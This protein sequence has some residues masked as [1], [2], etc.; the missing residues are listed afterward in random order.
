MPPKGS[1]LPKQIGG[2][3]A[4]KGWKPLLDALRK[5]RQPRGPLYDP[6]ATRDVQR[7]HI[8]LSLLLSSQTRDE[9][10]SAAME[11]LRGQTFVA[12]KKAK[13]PLTVDS[14]SGCTP[15]AVSKLTEEQ[16]KGLIFGVRFYNN[17]TRY[18]KAV[19]D[20]IVTKHGG[21]V[22]SDYDTL[23]AMPGL[24][25]KMVHLFM[26][27][28]DG[29]LTGIGVDT[30]V[31]RIARR[32]EWTPPSAKTP[33]ATRMA[34]EAWLPKQHWTEINE[35]LVG[36]GQTICR[37]VGPRCGECALSGMCPNAF[38]EESGTAAR[39]RM[40][41]DVAIVEDIEGA[42]PVLGKKRPRKE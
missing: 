39:S 36:L 15:A 3:S 8:L 33:E 4:P 14:L 1:V 40:K 32:F 16:V 12:D 13:P 21:V 22:P 26:Q 9:A 10:T 28:A 20:I 2:A 35:L 31:H 37:P 42:P 29:V 19:T 41:K 17:K 38:K 34:L 5:L 23:V 18:V 30:H 24:G 7:Y 11:R 27:C 6:T 25:P